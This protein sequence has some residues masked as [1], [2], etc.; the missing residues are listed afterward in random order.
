MSNPNPNQSNLVTGDDRHKLTREDNARGGVNSGKARRER[1]Q[2]R[3]A[4]DELLSKKMTIPE[5]EKKV[6]GVEAMTLRL[7]MA[8]LAGDT[9]AFELIRDTVGEKPAD[10][11]VIG[12]V[13]PDVVRAVDALVDGAL[14]GIPE[15]DDKGAGG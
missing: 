11:V 1:K 9:K 5:C 12:A 8:A 14:S 10:K 6:S 7:F 13:D 3:E 4:L 2:I 15:S